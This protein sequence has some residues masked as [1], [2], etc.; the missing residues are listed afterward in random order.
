MDYAPGRVARDREEEVTVKES[1]SQKGRREVREFFALVAAIALTL[2]AAL[3]AAVEDLLQA[4]ASALLGLGLLALAIGVFGYCLGSASRST[5]TPLARATATASVRPEPTPGP[6]EPTPSASPMPTEPTASASPTPTRTPRIDPAVGL[7]LSADVV[8]TDTG[9][10]GTAT[11]YG[12]TANA[13]GTVT[14]SVHNDR[15][16]LGPA[17]DAGTRPVINGTVAS[18]DAVSFENAAYAY[19]LAVY[20]GHGANP[21]RPSNCARLSVTLPPPVAYQIVGRRDLSLAGRSRYSIDAV[22]PGQLT[23]GQKIATLAAIARAERRQHVIVVDAYRTLAEARSCAYTVGQAELSTD[24]R[25]WDVRLSGDTLRFGKDNGQIQGVVALQVNER[26][27][28]A[29]SEEH[30]STPR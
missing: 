10:R 23:K 30:F 12:V 27:C 22:V 1:E 11:L 5:A 19:W 2:L 8:S 7:T 21:P 25:G 20:S 13:A 28:F 26:A 18:S 29:S 14:Y 15:S 4:S 3:R 16:C 9:V 24:G 6:A 17:V